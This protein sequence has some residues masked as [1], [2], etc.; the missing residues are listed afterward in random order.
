MLPPNLDPQSYSLSAA[1]IGALI[2]PELTINEANSIG[3]WLVLVGDYLLCF[4]GQ[5]ALVK[6][7]DPVHSDKAQSF[8]INTIMNVL[9]RMQEELEKLKKEKL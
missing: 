3:N 8:Q 4:A 7:R 5:K 1:I 6:S 9:N 2:S